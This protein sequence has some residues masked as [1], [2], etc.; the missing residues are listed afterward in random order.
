M[1]KSKNLVILIGHLG[2]D[3]ST[4]T[5]PTSGDSVS[6]FSLATNTDWKDKD[7]GEKKSNT[8]W[9]RIVFYKGLAEIAESYLKSGA[10]VYVEGHLRTRKWTDKENVVRYVT[11]VVGDDLIMLD[12]KEAE[13]ANESAA[14]PAKAAAKK[15]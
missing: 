10:R 9:H 3:P 15:K 14:K 12:R 1:S 13:A 7:T 6:S 11:E 2:E 8:E 5:I 4:D